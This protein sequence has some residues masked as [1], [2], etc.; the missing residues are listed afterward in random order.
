MDERILFALGIM[1]G[2]AIVLWVAAPV[3]AILFRNNN[4]RR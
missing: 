3:L 4:H 2:A 1:V